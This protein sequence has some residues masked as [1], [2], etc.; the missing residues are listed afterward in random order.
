MKIYV[1]YSSNGDY[2]NELYKAIT[3]SFLN[4][5][6]S[7]YFPHINTDEQFESKSF[8]EKDC[9]LVIADVSSSSIGTGIELGWA[10]IFGVPI[11]CMYKKGSKVSGSLKVVCDKFIEYSNI[12]EM[13][14]GIDKLI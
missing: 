9:D 11:I 14:N 5:K 12:E 3:N 8:F 10:N 6:Y 7:F 13:I 2:L 4:N 1:A